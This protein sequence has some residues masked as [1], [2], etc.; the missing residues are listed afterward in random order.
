LSIIPN[1]SSPGGVLDHTIE[2]EE[3]QHKDFFRLNHI[4]GYHELS[5]K[6]QIYFSSAVAKWDADFYIKVDDDVHVNLGQFMSFKFKAYKYCSK[7]S[8]VK[9]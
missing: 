9:V 7:K 3:E 8:L 6:T 5:S 4:E 2:A 1:S